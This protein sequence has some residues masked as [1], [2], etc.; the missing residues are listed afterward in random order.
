MFATLTNLH[1]NRSLC[2]LNASRTYL[3]KNIMGYECFFEIYVFWL[4]NS[5]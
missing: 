3:E 2:S 5:P 1:I 4:K